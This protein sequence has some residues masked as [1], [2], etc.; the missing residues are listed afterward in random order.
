MTGAATREHMGDI[1]A[2][3]LL[4]NLTNC[5]LDVS[6]IDAIIRA[7]PSH[8]AVIA[9][10]RCETVEC[11]SD[12]QGALHIAGNLLRLELE[13]GADVGLCPALGTLSAL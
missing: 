8:L 11:E 9:V 12:V 7:V 5:N 3:L 10:I 6:R 4:K 2:E 1:S 13:L